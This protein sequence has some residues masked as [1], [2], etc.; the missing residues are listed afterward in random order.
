MPRLRAPAIS[1][2]IVLLGLALPV[3]AAPAPIVFDFEDGLQGWE[4]H[5]GATR[6]QTQVLGGEWAIFMDNLVN[7]FVS[8]SMKVEELQAV[9]PVSFDQLIIE[10]SGVFVVRGI[11]LIANASAIFIGVNILPATGPPPPPMVAFIDNIT[12][13]PVPEPSS[14]L[15]LS[16]GIAGVVMI[17]RKLASRA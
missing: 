12:F 10:G 11:G 4:L 3:Q 2:L 15:L 5:G 9:G 1:A 16:L 13:H 6:V 17:R 7:G 14:W 8:I